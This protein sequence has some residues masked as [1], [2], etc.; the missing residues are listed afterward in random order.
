MLRNC[1]YA[2]NQKKY[3]YYLF[4]TLIVKKKYRNEGYSRIIMDLNSKIIKK[5]KKISILF[6]TNEMQK[7]Y[8]K[9][10]WRKLAK[11]EYKLIDFKTTKNVLIFNDKKNKKNYKIEY[12]IK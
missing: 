5:N 12:F 4:D 1:K 2:K 6:C 10:G 8:K 9:H 7:F 3:S 11:K